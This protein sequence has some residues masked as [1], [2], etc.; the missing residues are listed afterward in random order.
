[1]LGVLLAVLAGLASLRWRQGRHAQAESLYKRAIAIDEAKLGDK[2]PAVARDL[3][4]LGIV[5][6]AQKRY[7]DAEP[8]MKRSLAIRILRD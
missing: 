5:Y 3:A 7:A 6:W 2:S 4:G 8:L 1:M